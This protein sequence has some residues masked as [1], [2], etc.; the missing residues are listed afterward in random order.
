MLYIAIDGDNIG[1]SVERYVILEQREALSQYAETVDLEIK[2]LGEE[3]AELGAIIIF[4]GGD[5]VLAEFSAKQEIEP[6][7]QLLAHG[8]DIS[9]SVG[10][11]STMR[12]AYLALKMAKSSGKGCWV[13]FDSLCESTA[14]T[15]GLTE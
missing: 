5:S 7:R 4:C 6:I 15:K 10:S 8:A 14:L 11:G 3:L 2:R 1:A 13:S 12:E 9:V